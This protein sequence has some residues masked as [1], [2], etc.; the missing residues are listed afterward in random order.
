MSLPAEFHGL[1]M[2]WP[3][4]VALFDRQ[5]RIQLVN[6]AFAELYETGA[7]AV[8]GQ[9]IWDVVGLQADLTL[10]KRAWSNIESGVPCPSIDWAAAT[11]SGRTLWLSGKVSAFADSGWAA[12]A[13]DDMTHERSLAEQLR[14]HLAA[15]EALLASLPVTMLRV[16]YQGA[17]V[18]MCDN[19]GLVAQDM[20]VDGFMWT[21]A[22][23]TGLG[24]AVC[25][26]MRSAT[27]E[28]RAVKFRHAHAD[29]HCDVVVSPCGMSDTL[30]VLHDVT[31]SVLLD[32]A[33]REPIERM[34]LLIEG[35]DNVVFL[36]D[37]DLRVTYASP[38]VEAAIGRDLTAIHGT[39]LQIYAAFPDSLGLALESTLRAQGLQARGVFEFLAPDG[40][41]KH[42]QL[43]ITN[44]LG[45][46]LINA[47]VVNGNDVTQLVD[48]QQELTVRM[49]QVEEMNAAL[50][51]QATTDAMTGLL[52][53]MSFQQHYV[54]AIELSQR[55][56]SPFSV[57]MID[58]DFFKSVNDRFG[59]LVGDKI[60]QQVAERLRASCRKSDVVARYGGEEFAVLLP[61]T[62]TEGAKTIAESL[63]HAVAERP[64]EGLDLTISIGLA[65][66][67]PDDRKMG[68]TLGNADVALYMS[69]RSGRDQVTVFQES[70]RAA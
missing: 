57:L 25:E 21:M 38:A 32:R 20:V 3:R 43:D 16:D 50:A 23:P 26:A 61:N 55:E 64:L 37:S 30:I 58:I 2:D 6:Q 24:E 7:D 65:T 48:L 11:P 13:I 44:H 54:Q 40:R 4:P 41:L 53:H 42:L 18:R 22:L 12:L 52:N 5:G 46:P 10:V 51:R 29:R 70:D 60:L 45:H 39:S 34:Q 56:N 27:L 33:K 69:K 62:D 28:Q 14:D 31:D 66:C 68:D 8:V 36:L 15:D 1:F 19:A 47:V 49:E 17:L 67:R 59:H 9:A 63:R 35:S